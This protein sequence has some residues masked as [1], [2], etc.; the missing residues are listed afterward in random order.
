MLIL[1]TNKILQL[2]IDKLDKQDSTFNITMKNMKQL[3]KGMYVY[4]S[5]IALYLY[6]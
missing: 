5:V 1:A 6:F 2:I 3:V 4:G